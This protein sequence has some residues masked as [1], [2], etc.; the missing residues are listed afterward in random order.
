[1]YV[2]VNSTMSTKNVLQM[3]T[4][5]RKEK[6]LLENIFVFIVRS[7]EFFQGIIWY[8]VDCMYTPNINV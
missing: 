1:M 7:I 2:C 3:K 8:S 4:L 5:L 6:V